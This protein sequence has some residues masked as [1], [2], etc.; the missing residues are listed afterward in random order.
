M[1][2]SFGQIGFAA[3]LVTMMSP[4]AAQATILGGD[5]AACSTGVRDTAVLVRVSG[6]KTRTGELR[7]QL[8]GDKPEDF[9]APGKKLRRIDLPVT[10]AGPM[11]VCIKAPGDGAY[12]I[13]VRHDLD[14]DNKTGWSDG[15]G[16]S[17]NPHLSLF[18][19]KPRLN[20]VV[21]R[22]AGHTAID[23]ILNYRQG[24]SIGPIR[25]D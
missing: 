6:F 13:A 10:P 22:V 18:S 9:L 3:L 21:F 15:G 11:A 24:L 23:V 16:F 12:A 1:S 4:V 5:A 14:G 8:Y 20:Q 2:K 19:L 7:V 25:Q 17:R